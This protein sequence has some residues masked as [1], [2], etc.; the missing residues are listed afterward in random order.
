MS[1]PTR[2]ILDPIFGNPTLAAANNGKAH[3]VRG[4]TSPLD[5]KSPTGWLACLYGGVQ[6]GDDWA[7]VNIPASEVR[8]TEFNAAQWSYYMT[9]TE[10][11]GVNIVIWVHDTND[12]DKRAEITQ[13][14]GHGDLPKAGGWNAFKFT[15][16]TEG[17]FFFGENTT[18]TGLTAGTQYS[19]AAFQADALFEK[20]TIYRITLEYGWEAAGTFEEAY[21]ADVKLNGI[22]IFLKPG[23]DEVYEITKGSGVVYL[24][25]D[26]AGAAA[27][28]RFETVSTRLIDAYITVAT[29]N[30]LFGTSAAQTF[31]VAVGETIH[32]SRIDISTLYFKNANGNGTVSILAAR[33]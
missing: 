9:N 22:P 17:M 14:G 25:S 6:T 28:R 1:V 20:W 13:L 7:R 24:K 32:F 10:T 12:F 3:W 26:T 16:A 29:Q 4:E 5:Q 31:P 11:M 2:R 23:L 15:S 19:W 27:A 30:Q 8:V 18:G 33:E 21:V